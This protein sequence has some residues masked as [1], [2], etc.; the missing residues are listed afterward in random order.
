MKRLARLAGP[1]HP[2]LTTFS[3]DRG[4]TMRWL[5]RLALLALFAIAA[6]LGFAAAD[7]VAAK[8]EAVNG[9]TVSRE[10]GVRVWRAAHPVRKAQAGCCVQPV[11]QAVV[12]AEPQ[13]YP[14]LV[15]SHAFRPK[16]RLRHHHH[17]HRHH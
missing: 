9:G 17:H 16:L 6:V 14:V 3:T 10:H 2:L 8:P 1:I 7:P 11:S 4:L 12:I 5:A 13:A 15:A